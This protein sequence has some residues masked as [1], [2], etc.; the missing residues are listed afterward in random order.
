VNL[1]GN[2]QIIRIPPE[3]HTYLY[4]KSGSNFFRTLP[5][6]AKWIIS[7]RQ[8]EVRET[9]ER[10]ETQMTRGFEEIKRIQDLIVDL[11]TALRLSK[12]GRVIPGLLMS[13]SYPT[14]ATP[15]FGGTTVW[16]SVSSLDFFVEESIYALNQD[17][18]DTMNSLFREITSWRVSSIMSQLDIP[19]YRFHSAYLGPIEERL[20]DQIIALES[21]YLGD[22]QELSYKLAMRTAYLLGS[23]REVR[24]E[25]FN[26][27]KTAYNYRSKIIHGNDPP[28]REQL[29]ELVPKV[30]D[31]L[32]QSLK[33]YLF[34]LND[35]NNMR[36]IQQ[37]LLDDSILEGG[38]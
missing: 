2:V 37:Q 3:F 4:E 11:I 25:I 24:S 18:I 9:G 29:R 8:R 26:N 30:E 22:P 15:S 19:F 32:R 20:V 21:L 16:T 10:V 5:S 33:K 17:E 28:T 34:L 38:Q 23:T 1:E 27:M 31:Y 13:A 12:E 7:I 14:G 36:G 35:G 6:E